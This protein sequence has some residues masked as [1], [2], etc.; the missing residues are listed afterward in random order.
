MA[1]IQESLAV[2][3]RTGAA[4]PADFS[5]LIVG[6]TVQSTAL[7][8]R[9]TPRSCSGARRLAWVARKTG[10]QLRQ[11]YQRVG[12]HALIAHQRYAHAKQFKRANRSL[13]TIRTYLGRVTRD[14]VRKIKG[15]A[16]L[17]SVF[18]HPLMLARRVREQLK[19][20][21]GK[22]VYSLHA[23]EVEASAKARPIGPM[24][25]RQGSLATTLHRSKGGQ[26]IAHAKRCRQPLRRHTSR[27]SR[28]SYADPRISRSS[29]PRGYRD[30]N[31]PSYHKFKVYISGEEARHRDDQTRTPP[32]LGGQ[33][34]HRPCQGRA[35]HRS[36]LLA[37]PMATPPTP[38][39]PQPATTPAGSSNGWLSVSITW[40]PSTSLKNR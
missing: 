23:P 26:F 28:R 19:H 15:D 14:I 5:K 20:Q 30:H 39:S 10:V 9:P 1:L 27:G 2:A 21:R 34:G 13:R 7:A 11:S 25:R 18:A 36:T 22:K 8:F 6:T 33:T 3:T 4:R 29:S 24:S 12:K 31:A 40:P 17:E 32:P 35:S 38:F 16:A 37:G